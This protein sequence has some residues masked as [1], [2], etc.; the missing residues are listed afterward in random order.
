FP[1]LNAE[2]G[3][4]KA[5]NLSLQREKK[6]F[7]LADPKFLRS[8]LASTPSR[9]LSLVTVIGESTSKWNVSLYGYPR[10]TFAPLAQLANLLVF[11]D[12]VAPDT[13]T[14]PSL[15]RALTSDKFDPTARY[16]YK[17]ST[18]SH[19]GE[20]ACGIHK[21]VIADDNFLNSVS[22]C[23]A[24]TAL[25][26]RWQQVITLF[27]KLICTLYWEER[28]NC[29]KNIRVKEEAREIALSGHFDT[30]WYLNR[31]YDV[32]EAGIDPIEHYI[33][34][35]AHEGRDPSPRFSTSD[36]LHKH[37]DVASSG[38]NPL[39]HYLR[40]GMRESGDFSLFT[41]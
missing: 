20:P 8:V 2:L 19:D 5:A 14:Y 25:E 27:S 18:L 31:Y 26:G 17:P 35:G 30:L 38:M 21:S 7:E 39:L 12:V 3:K 15:M 1:S 34:Y 22:K 36:Y 29:E 24:A 33:L 4:L 28:L 40:F 9:K 13:N 11:E 37:P 16:K 23:R 41:A 6:I 32:L 10:K